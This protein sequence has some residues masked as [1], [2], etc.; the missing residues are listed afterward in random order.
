MQSDK[1]KAIVRSMTNE[2]KPDLDPL[3]PRLEEALML[4]GKSVTKFSY[5]HFG[6]SAFIKKM[7]EGRKFRQPMVVKIEAVL[8]EYGA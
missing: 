2:T 4:S 8:A 6:D 1:G 5:V 3:A 7:R